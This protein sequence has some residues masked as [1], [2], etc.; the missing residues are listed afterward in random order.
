M[1]S[2][3]QK[4]GNSL[5]IRIPMHLAKQLHLHAGSSVTLK[6]EEEGRLIIQ[7][8]RYDLKTMVEAITPKNQHHSLIEDNT[9]M[10]N[11]EW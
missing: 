6:I 10:R 5:G 4:W 9:Q 1:Q 2:F 7:V 11:E 8:P 3:I